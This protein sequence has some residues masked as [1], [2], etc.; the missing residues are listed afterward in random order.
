MVS[1]ASKFEHRVDINGRRGISRTTVAM[2]GRSSV[3]TAEAGLSQTSEGSQ[4]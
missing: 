4:G 1:L 2:T 3:V